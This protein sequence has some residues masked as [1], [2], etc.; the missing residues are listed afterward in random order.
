MVA[1]FTEALVSAVSI[2][3]VYNSSYF[4]SFEVVEGI[5]GWV[6]GGGGEGGGDLTNTG[7]R[8]VV[9]MTD[10]YRSPF[11]FSKVIKL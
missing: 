5:T 9:N 2:I 6:G 11:V 8:H 1:C 3:E 4:S 7:T 10:F